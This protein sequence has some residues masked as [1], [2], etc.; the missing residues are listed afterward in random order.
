MSSHH[1][2]SLLELMITLAIVAVLASLSYPLYSHHLQTARRKHAELMLLMIASQLEEYH[3]THDTYRG[4]TLADLPIST[5][6]DI[7]YHFLIEQADDQHYLLSATPL[8][9]QTDDPCGTLKLNA[10]NQK[11]AQGSSEACW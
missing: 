5:H 9:G 4:A 2:F 3:S 11:M 8:N 10:I 1:G 6:D 7:S